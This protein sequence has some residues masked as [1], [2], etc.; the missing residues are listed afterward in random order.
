MKFLIKGTLLNSVSEKEKN[1]FKEYCRQLGAALAKG[2]HTIILACYEGIKP[3]VSID[4]YITVGPSIISGADEVAGEGKHQVKLFG[5]QGDNDFIKFEED[6][7]NWKN[8]ETSMHPVEEVWKMA[9]LPAIAEADGVILI[10]GYSNTTAIGKTA[11]LIDKPVLAIPVFNGAAKKLWN[12]LSAGYEPKT[13]L[14]IEILRSQNINNRGDKIIEYAVKLFNSETSSGVAMQTT[15]LTG[16]LVLVGCWIALFI[17]AFGLMKDI[18]FFLLLGISA[19]LGTF[20]R[21]SWNLLSGD[22]LRIAPRELLQ[23]ITVSILLAFGF[24]LLYLAGVI[25]LTG[26]V[27][28]ITGQEDFTRISVSM[29]LLGF[30]AALLFDKAYKIIKELLEKKLSN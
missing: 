28:S 8:I 10:G 17:N 7:N 25:V 15:I 2:G 5:V 22:K 24:S 1:S 30:G 14:S 16:A 11:K 27:I 19:L 3:D 6:R 13:G 9:M 4:D 26:K 12:E 29:S 18:S 21:N 23:E 20:L